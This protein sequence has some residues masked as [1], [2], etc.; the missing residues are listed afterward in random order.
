[1]S[2]E[3]RAELLRLM[4]VQHDSDWGPNPIVC[5]WC[6]CWLKYGDNSSGKPV[7][8]HAEDCFAARFLKRPARKAQL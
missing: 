7:E 2:A 8:D 4:P 5:R 6:G 1:M 3:M